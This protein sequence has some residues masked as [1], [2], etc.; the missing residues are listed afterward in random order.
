MG[1]K[2]IH[3]GGTGF[4][5]ALGSSLSTLEA[6]LHLFWVRLLCDATIYGSQGPFYLTLSVKGRVLIID[7]CLSCNRL[8]LYFTITLII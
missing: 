5:V 8:C 1:S 3:H 4:S 6:Q 2:T 7:Y